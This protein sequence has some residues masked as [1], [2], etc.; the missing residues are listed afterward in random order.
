MCSAQTAER[1]E[2][3]PEQLEGNANALSTGQGG[4]WKA[5]EEESRPRP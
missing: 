5:E 3:G 4:V 2:T 1:G